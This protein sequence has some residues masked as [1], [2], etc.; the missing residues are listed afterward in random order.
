MG[1]I[2][3]F[4]V[5]VTDP[6]ASLFQ[7]DHALMVQAAHHLAKPAPTASWGIDPDL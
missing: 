4:G 5:I 2:K 3:R 1:L 7:I 6:N